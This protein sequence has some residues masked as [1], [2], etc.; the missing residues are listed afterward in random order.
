MTP[1]RALRILARA[2]P[3][4]DRRRARHDPDAPPITRADQ[5]RPIAC[6]PP[7]PRRRAAI[8]LIAQPRLPATPKTDAPGGAIVGPPHTLSP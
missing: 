8:P 4:R 3:P 6:G 5:S 2:A 7:H 1:T